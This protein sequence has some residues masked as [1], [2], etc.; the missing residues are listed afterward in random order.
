MGIL[1]KMADS[2]AIKKIARELSPFLLRGYGGGEF[3]TVPQV[4]RAMSET[5]CNLNFMDHALAM[6]CDKE[7]FSGASDESYEDLREVIGDVCFDGNAEFSWDD[8]SGFD[9]V[10]GDGGD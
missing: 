10:G 2:R 9:S 7:T 1:I 5:D 8:A 6:F 3:Y 4:E